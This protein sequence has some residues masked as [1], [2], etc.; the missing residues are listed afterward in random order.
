MRTAMSITL[1]AAAGAALG[2]TGSSIPGEACNFTVG[3]AMEFDS[4][5]YPMM[6]VMPDLDMQ[7]GETVKMFTTD[8]FEPVGCIEDRPEVV[9]AE[10][11]DPAAVAV[12]ISGVVLAID[13]LDVAD[14]VRVTVK[15][16]PALTEPS[17][18]YDFW[19]YNTYEFLVR[20][21]PPPAGR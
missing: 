20:V 11:A 17:W 15:P 19:Y 9:V 7:V 5:G 4:R 3:A 8:H 10:S 18:N 13:A 14:S 16:N 12:S 1:A 2:C 21:R 6:P